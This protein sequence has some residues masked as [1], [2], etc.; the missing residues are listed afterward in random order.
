MANNNTNAPYR[1]FKRGE[2][3]HA[4][5]SFVANG[6]RI[7]IR[8][9]TGES[10]AE[11]AQN[12]CINQIN[13]VRNA[14]AITHE[15]S[16]DAACAKW[17]NEYG[18]NL[19]SANDLLSKLRIL[20]TVIDGNIK[21]S[22]ITKMDV[23]HLVT[24]FTSNGKS[25]ATANRYL[26]VLSAIC[27]RAKNNWDCR[28]PD[29]KI[30]SFRLKEPKENI[31]YF[32]DWNEIQQLLAA[33]APHI[34]PIILTALYTGLRRGR[35]LS[36]KWEQIDWDNNQIIYMGKD[37]N[38][39]SVPMVKPLRE[40]LQQLPR[41]NEYVFTYGGH[42]I[43]D[44]KSAW[45]AAFERAKIPYRNFH[46]LRHTTA[47]WLLRQTGNLR[48]VQTVL[49]HSNISITTKYAHL[50]NNESQTA[51]NGLFT[52]NLHTEPVNPADTQTPPSSYGS[53][54]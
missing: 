36:L 52:Q 18:Q 1:L 22:Q 26:C 28:I 3:Y 43:L 23:N 41:I 5:I 35:I 34:R 25:N 12:W 20:L 54:G 40:T 19:S 17:W 44:I 30:L 32:R 14:P 31:K 6:R 7:V 45:R 48:I 10:E 33:S 24:Y 16:L 51:L 39:H 46:T 9:S 49:G 8:Q 47:T 13:A 11:R 29:F 15:I 50:V 53:E 2:I 42:R 4:Y 37:G 21:L 38:P 27:T